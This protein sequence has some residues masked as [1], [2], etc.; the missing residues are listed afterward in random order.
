MA[1]MHMTSA[2]MKNRCLSKQS[3]DVRFPAKLKCALLQCDFA[4]QAVKKCSRD[5]GR[6]AIL[7]P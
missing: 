2:E 7:M 3:S 4:S 6:I 5:S 1:L